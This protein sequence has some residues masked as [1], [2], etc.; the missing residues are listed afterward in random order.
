MGLVDILSLLNSQSLEITAGLSIFSAII[1]LWIRGREVDISG[2]TS[3]GKLQIEQL[4]SLMEQNKI[5]ADDLSRLRL[6]MAE[7]FVLLQSTRERVIELEN[8]LIKFKKICNNCNDSPFEEEEK[9]LFF[10]K[11]DERDKN[12]KEH[13]DLF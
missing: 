13:R 8:K 7:T 12:Y 6:E 1:A 5:L 3:I 9:L 11:L 2:V 4:K 10:Q